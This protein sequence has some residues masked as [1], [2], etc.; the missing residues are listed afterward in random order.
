M[1]KEHGG[2]KLIFATYASWIRAWGFGTQPGELAQAARFGTHCSE[3]LVQDKSKMGPGGWKR[4][5]SY[6]EKR[7]APAEQ[8]YNAKTKRLRMICGGSDGRGRVQG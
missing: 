5:E 8:I 7:R 1:G 3:S 2:R 4:K 6:A